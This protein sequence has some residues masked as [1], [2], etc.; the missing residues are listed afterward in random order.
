MSNRKQHSDVL[1]LKYQV[2]RRKARP[3]GSP[4]HAEGMST[5]RHSRE[6]R[7]VRS[8]AGYSD[9]GRG[10][11]Q[12]R[13]QVASNAENSCKAKAGGSDMKQTMET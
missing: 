6:T 8:L 12:C 5:E 7:D 3:Q 4:E 2:Q 13:G 10:Q 1:N 11:T 9:R